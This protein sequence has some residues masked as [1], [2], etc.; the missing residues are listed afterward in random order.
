[1]EWPTEKGMNRLSE[2]VFYLCW[3]GGERRFEP[4]GAVLLLA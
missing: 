4:W 3:V 1:M 2:C